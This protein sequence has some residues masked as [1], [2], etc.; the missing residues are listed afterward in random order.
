MSG[1]NQ[2]T[3]AGSGYG[4][5]FLN[6][7][8]FGAQKSNSEYGPPNGSHPFADYNAGNNFVGS[9]PATEGDAQVQAAANWMS[10]VNRGYGDSEMK[11]DVLTVANTYGQRG[12]P[13]VIERIVLKTALN[14]ATDVHF[15]ILPIR[16]MANVELSGVR[17][18]EF[19]MG[20]HMPQVAAEFIPPHYKDFKTSSFEKRPTRY[21]HGWRIGMDMAAL[22]EGQRLEEMYAIG[23]ANDF[24]MQ[25]AMTVTA[26]LMSVNDQYSDDRIREATGL[27]SMSE[28]VDQQRAYQ[29]AT[30]GGHIIAHPGMFGILNRY[31][32]IEYMMSWARRVMRSKGV[33]PTH[34]LAVAGSLEAEA[35]EEYRNDYARRGAEGQRILRDGEEAIFGMVQRKFG[36]LTIAE[37]LVYEPENSAVDRFC[38]LVNNAQ[39]GRFQLITNEPYYQYREKMAATAAAARGA[40]GMSTDAKCTLGGPR[41]NDLHFLNLSGDAFRDVIT[42]DDLVANAVCFDGHGRLDVMAYDEVSAQYKTYAERVLGMNITDEKTFLADPFLVYDRDHFRTVRVIGNMDMRH[43]D[44]KATKLI[45]DLACNSIAS[46]VGRE[47]YRRIERLTRFMDRNY[48]VAPDRDGNVEAFAVATA[49]ENVDDGDLRAQGS[50]QPDTLG[51]TQGGVRLPRVG[52]IVVPGGLESTR[53]MAFYNRRSDTVLCKVR[54]RMTQNGPFLAGAGATSAAA[55]TLSWANPHYVWLDANL[56]RAGIFNDATG[57]FIDEPDGLAVPTNFAGGNFVQSVRLATLPRNNPSGA[58]F[59]FFSTFSDMRGIVS[60]LENSANGNGWNDVLNAADTLRMVREGVEA[61]DEYARAV[62]KIFCPEGYNGARLDRNLYFRKELLAAYQRTGDDDI[63]ENTAFLQNALCGVR[64]QLGIVAPFMRSA[65]AA[66]SVAADQTFRFGAAIEAGGV[67]INFLA[68]RVTDANNAYDPALGP[69]LPGVASNARED[70]LANP[71]EFGSDTNYPGLATL[72]FSLLPRVTAAQADASSASATNRTLGAFGPGE[73]SAAARTAGFD[74]GE[75]IDA[76]AYLDDLTDYARGS[77]GQAVPDDNNIPGD[78]FDRAK[79]Y[80]LWGNLLSKL[81]TARFGV[82]KRYYGEDA[83]GAAWRE[84]RERWAR[85]Y[86]DGESLNE[87]LR[88]ITNLYIDNIGDAQID[89]FLRARPDA[90]SRDLDIKLNAFVISVNTLFNTVESFTGTDEDGNDVQAP[91]WL[92]DE[93]VREIYDASYRQSAA[94]FDRLAANAASRDAPALGQGAATMGRFWEFLDD[95][96]RVT[97]I[98]GTRLSVSPNYWR[99][100]D[101]LMRGIMGPDAPAGVGAAMSVLRPS[102]SVDMGSFVGAPAVATRAQARGWQE[103]Y[104][105]NYDDIIKHGGA[106]HGADHSTLLFKVG[107]AYAGAACHA[108]G[109]GRYRRHGGAGY[110]DHGVDDDPYGVYSGKRT[111]N[112]VAQ[113]ALEAVAGSIMPGVHPDEVPNRHFHNRLNGL[114]D[115]CVRAWNRRA[116]LY[117]LLGAVPSAQ[118]LC[119]LHEN[120]IPSP[121]SLIVMEPFI[122][123]RMNSMIITQGGPDTGYLGY[124]LVAQTKGFDSETRMATAHVSMWLMGLIKEP[125][126]VLQIPYASFAGLV[127]GGTMRLARNMRSQAHDVSDRAVD[128]DAENPMAR[129][130]DAFVA[131]GGGNLTK[132]NIGGALPLAG[133]TTNPE[134]RV[135]GDRVMPQAYVPEIPENTQAYPSAIMMNYKAQFPRLNGRCTEAARAPSSIGDIRQYPP[136]TTNT[137]WNGW[138][139]QGLQW[140]ADP[141]NLNHFTVLYP[142]SGVFAGIGPGDGPKLRGEPGV[143]SAPISGQGLLVKSQ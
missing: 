39:V 77:A 41:L 120:G 131:I 44:T 33:T 27:L 82:L 84:F 12:A 140:Q 43:T 11:R 88:R 25:A 45:L 15:Q 129:Q 102:S 10:G 119:N 70:L 137:R 118:L 80:I 107:P 46:T 74:F 90:D 110:G 135:S 68:H 71:L 114:G 1:V 30:N 76:N 38:L 59:P 122:D 28:I 139:H 78:D 21:N 19:N 117:A 6:N 3:P 113:D 75:E 126:N 35:Y 69:T 8:I 14:P 50:G 99:Q 111:R 87:T 9:A 2:N 89:N 127:R 31:K 85:I 94:Q 26:E 133:A 66:G 62:K 47:V 20:F 54:M 130:A 16:Q 124:H 128:W 29:G 17:V 104:A 60:T 73:I 91:E 86:G 93:F 96:G 125:K 105:A 142:G 7:H 108:R 24:H 63:D 5:H 48:N 109:R 79:A 61:A 138:L 100:Y 112:P 101:R 83:S 65:A 55:R 13:L 49:W 42:Y 52:P 92:S 72:R 23:A 98:V 106:C 116:P 64:G 121:I 53:Y 81:Q 56:A 4:L 134:Y 132:R 34:I 18:E 103:I 57:E 51:G 123:F 32:G 143:L 58:M 136:G 37:E 115:D 141:F 67:N 40:G 97:D 95:T 22:P 36:G